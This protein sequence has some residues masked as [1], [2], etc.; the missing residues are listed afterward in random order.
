MTNTQSS[1]PMVRLLSI[2]AR[3]RDPDKGCPWDLEQTFT[4][5][6]PYTLEEAYEVV[7]A[8]ETA[9][10]QGLQGELGD[11]LLQVVFHARMAEEAG[12]F[13]FD[14]VASAIADKM[15]RRH[16]HVF[17]DK[18]YENLAAQKADWEALKQKEK[19]AQKIKQDANESPA[20]HR[21]IFD[22][23]P[24][25]L[26][27]LVR[28]EKIQKR[29]ARLGFDWR[30]PEEIFDKIHEEIDELRQEFTAG[31]QAGVE[32]ELGDL[33]FAVTNLARRLGID[34][35]SALRKANLKFINRFKKLLQHIDRN[36]KKIEHL[37]LDEM[38][39]IWQ[40]VKK[41]P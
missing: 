13:S 30:H 1:S 25:P 2:M 3:L 20:Q 9:D 34:S 35:E 28:A 4:T 36:N 12:L 7:D 19:T 10:M 18:K 33:L 40:A 21:D 17:A 16:P 6:A 5:I 31:D 15:V 22:D 26:P 38:E 11:L 24:L 37:S 41:T 8:I 39:T 32:E 14:D 27:A 23:I 29:A